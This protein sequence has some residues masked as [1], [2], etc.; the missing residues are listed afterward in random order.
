MMSKVLTHAVRLLARRA[1]GSL[2]LKSKLRQK[3][4]AE[5]EVHDALETCQRLHYQSDEMFCEQL[6]RI[7]FQQGYG[8]LRIRQELQAKGI[9]KELIEQC[10]TCESLDWHQAAQAVWEKKASSYSELT[11]KEQQKLQRFLLYRGFPADL[12][13]QI[14]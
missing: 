6:C 2:E 14:S 5:Q 12:I 13:R 10:L 1:H 7:R 11:L 9:A 8:P 4:Y 3:G